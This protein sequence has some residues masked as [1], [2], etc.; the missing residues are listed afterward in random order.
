LQ[1]DRQSADAGIEVISRKRPLP[2]FVETSI[3]IQRERMGGNHRA[4]PQQR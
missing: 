4:T 3:G 2:A 1:S